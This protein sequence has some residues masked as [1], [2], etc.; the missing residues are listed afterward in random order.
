MTTTARQAA[1]LPVAHHLG[2]TEHLRIHAMRCAPTDGTG[3]RIVVTA[4]PLADKYQPPITCV[5]KEANGLAFPGWI[6][7][8]LP[9]VRHADELRE[10]LAIKFGPFEPA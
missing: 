6:D 4:F 1:A 2:D 5:L 3:A 9:T 10:F 7:S 8:L